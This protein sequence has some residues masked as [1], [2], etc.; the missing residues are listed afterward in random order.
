MISCGDD[1]TSETIITPPAQSALRL[2]DKFSAQREVKEVRAKNWPVRAIYWNSSTLSG[3]RWVEYDRTGT[4]I[5]SSFLK[6]GDI[7]VE[8]LQQGLPIWLGGQHIYTP[9]EAISKLDGQTLGLENFVLVDRRVCPVRP[10]N[11]AYEYYR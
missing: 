5:R 11:T 8:Y 2:V 6:R 4:V 3:G 7:L 10:E 1:G 9:V